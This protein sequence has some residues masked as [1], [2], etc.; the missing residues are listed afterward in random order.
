MAVND[1]F[2]RSPVALNTVAQTITGSWVDLGP[3]IETAGYKN[4]GLWYSIDI[5][6]SLN[7]RLRMLAKTALG[8]ADEYQSQIRTVTASSVCLEP[9]YFELNNDADQKAIISICIDNLAPV[10]QFQVQAGTA[11]ATPGTVLASYSLG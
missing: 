6:D 5:N 8:A 9:E 10:V 4:I 7:V 2:R 1:G 11:G 3:E